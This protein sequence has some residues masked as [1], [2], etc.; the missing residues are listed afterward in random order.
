VRAVREASAR[1]PL[2]LTITA[3]PG[4]RIF[5]DGR[6]TGRDR[7][8][9]PL[10]RGEHYLWVER[11]A[12]PP[13]TRVV[14]LAAPV[15][16]VVPDETVRPPDDAELLR[17]AARLGAGVP[18]VV[19]LSRQGGVAM[20]EL[21]SLERRGGVLRGAVRLG[22]S[23]AA[24]AR[25]LRETAARALRELPAARVDA[26]LAAGQTDA[27][28]ERRWYKNRWVWLAAGAA[29]ALVA[30]SPFLLDSSG[31]SSPRYGAAN[32]DPLQ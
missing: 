2:A 23:P 14:A 15:A 3:P 13:F 10:L 27:P 28:A 19:A 32:T 30:A 31:N 1:P 9:E 29:A 21:R 20:V 6:S 26:S 12:A 25:D 24:D 7:L 8:S 11:P 16:L 18:L 4:S 22:P 5:I 17:R